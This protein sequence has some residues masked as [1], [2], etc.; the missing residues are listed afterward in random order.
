M[1]ELAITYAVD[2]DPF[3]GPEIA[4]L[5]PSI[6]PQLE[7]WVACALGGEDANRAYNESV[8]LRLSGIFH[9]QAFEKALAALIAR[10]E[11]LRSS[12]SADGSRICIYKQLPAQ[13]YYEDL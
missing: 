11:G 12:F 13:F 8:S 9:Q 3:D 1:K 4:R 10:H 6:E 2:F 5:A 7:L